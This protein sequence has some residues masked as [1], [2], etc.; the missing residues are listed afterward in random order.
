MRPQINGVSLSLVSRLNVLYEYSLFLGI[1][2][3]LALIMANFFPDLYHKIAPE[4]VHFLVNDILMAPFF[5]LAAKE[6]REAQLPGGKLE[7]IRKAALPLMATIGGMVG[8]IAIFLAGTAAWNP[9]L[10]NGWAVPTATDI[11]FALIGARLIFGSMKHPAVTFLLLLAIADDAGGM[12]IMAIFYPVEPVDV[13]MLGL[14]ALAIVMA[15]TMYK[16]FQ[17]TSFWLYL[18]IPGSI[19]WVGFY[20]A[21]LHPALSLVPLAWCMP[22]EHSDLGFYEEESEDAI[23][24]NGEE[25]EPH[26]TDTLNQFAFR[27]K[28]PIEWF[29]GIFGFVNAGVEIGNIGSGTILVATSLVVGKPVGIVLFTLAGIV[30]GLKLPDGLNFRGVFVLGILAGIGFTVAI[31][32]STVAFPNGPLQGEVKLGALVSIFAGVIAFAAAKLLRVGIFER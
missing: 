17:V 30:L 12:L 7:D 31:F 4:E 28:N 9:A 1:A 2:A 23:R 3:P 29:L 19:S 10:K 5:L 27:M 15:L 14:I 16:K 18:I 20:A 26:P 13:K 21:G 22:H 32:V 25:A 8:P 24:I 6:I 11:A